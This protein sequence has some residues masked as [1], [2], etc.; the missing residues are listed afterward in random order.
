M[1]AALS[2]LAA[3]LAAGLS[4]I[5]AIGAQNAFVL[6]QGLRREHVLPVVL[7]CA[8]S[9]LVLIAAGTAGLGALVT[10]APTLLTVVR[11]GGAAFL[12]TLGALAARRALRPGGLDPASGAGATSARSAVGTS[13]AL[14]WLNPHVYL[15]TVLLLGSLA[16]GYAAAHAGG[17]AAYAGA[18]DPDTARW[19]FG[20]GAMV[21]SLVWFTALG[22]GARLLAPVFA[23]PGAWRVLDGVIAAVMATIG[24]SLLLGG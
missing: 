9:D 12:L 23:R 2:P 7:V 16:A 18:G 1:L 22:F 20:A 10:G 11:W 19:L 6:R 24:V 21:A 17:T 14:T 8:L 5:V 15:D 4:L 13:L 3:G